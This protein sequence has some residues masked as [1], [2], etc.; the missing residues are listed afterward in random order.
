MNASS[1]EQEVVNGLSGSFWLRL[2]RAA[3]VLA[4]TTL[5]LAAC[6][7]YRAAEPF[8][9]SAREA[10]LVVGPG[11]MGRLE[12]NTGSGIEI[13]E[14]V[15]VSVSQHGSSL[16]DAGIPGGSTSSELN[17]RVA[18]KAT[19]GKAN[20]V[21][22]KEIDAVVARRL[23]RDLGVSEVAGPRSLEVVPRVIINAAGP[24]QS[25][26]HVLLRI[27]LVE[28]G[29][30]VWWTRVS[31]AADG[32]RP[33]GEWMSSREAFLRFTEE[34]IDRAGKGVALL[35]RGEEL[36]PSQAQRIQGAFPWYGVFQGVWTGRIAPAPWSDDD[37]LVRLQLVDLSIGAG[38]HVLPT[39]L[40]RV[41]R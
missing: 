8:P 28:G 31:G 35:S 14:R 13:S 32:I 4:I 37:R 20:V 3:V 27:R 33:I 21:P 24:D 25:T 40:V 16:F 41:A 36:F 6:H 1:V 22:A 30:E 12:D 11:N 9:S 26:L 7:T 38:L 5:T 18:A 39:Q 17:Q 34:A 29:K 15:F 23:R 10:R 2:R 19:Q